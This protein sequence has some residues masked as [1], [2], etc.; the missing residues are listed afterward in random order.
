M[1]RLPKDIAQERMHQDIVRLLEEYRVNSPVTM[2]GFTTSPHQMAASA[3]GFVPHPVGK[4]KK[5][6]RKAKH[7]GEHHHSNKVDLPPMEKKK[8][9]NKGHHHHGHHHHHHAG[10][11]HTGHQ[12]AGAMEAPAHCDTL[13]SPACMMELPPSYES[14]CS[15]GHLVLS[16]PLDIPNGATMNTGIVPIEAALPGHLSPEWLE[17]IHHLP[18]GAGM[19]HGAIQN[20]GYSQN[21]PSSANGSPLTTSSQGGSPASRTA[22]SPLANGHQQTYSSPSYTATTPSPG[23]ITSPGSL[24]TQSPMSQPASISPPQTASSNQHVS[25]PRKMHYPTSPTHLQV[26]V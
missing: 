11:H 23:S 18:P 24:P 1:D 22:T 5:N 6:S 8:K 26:N 19:I 4:P 17:T 7:H 2:N 13:E 14:A 20:I 9:K 21:S 10:H 16:Q 15:N 12:A 3:V 25:P